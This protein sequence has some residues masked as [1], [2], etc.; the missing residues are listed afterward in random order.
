MLAGGRPGCSGVRNNDIWNTMIY[1]V[2]V[3]VGGWTEGARGRNDF[4]L[5]RACGRG[6]APRGRTLEQEG[7]AKIKARRI[8][9]SAPARSPRTISTQF[10]ISNNL[11]SGI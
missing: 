8:A 4:Y 10:Q 2:G 5:S 9:S 3:G 1:F 7:R 6:D 11:E